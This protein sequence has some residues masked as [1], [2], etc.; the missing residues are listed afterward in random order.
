MDK[1]EALSLADAELAEL[2]RSTYSQLIERLLDKQETFERVGD[3]GT[4]YQFELQAF[5]DDKPDGNLRVFVLIDDR[6]WRAFAPLS[7]DFIRAPDGAF[8]DE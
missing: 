4:R 5:W 8:I 3:S 1:E 7:V 2:R 6:G